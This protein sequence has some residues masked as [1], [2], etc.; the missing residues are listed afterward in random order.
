MPDPDMNPRLRLAIQEARAENMPKDN[1]ER[2]IKKAL[3]GDLANYEAV[4]YEGYA[5]GG[6]AVIVEA[7]TDNRNRTGGVVR[8]VFTKYGG[9]LGATGSVSHMFNHIGEITYKAEAGSA[10]AVLEAAIEPGPTMFNRT[11]T[12][13]S[14]VCAFE[15]LWARSPLHSRRSSAKRKASKRLEAEPDDAGRRGQRADDLENAC[16]ARRRRRRAKRL[17]EL[18]DLGRGFEEA[19]GGVMALR[20][21]MAVLRG[22]HPE[23]L[24][25]TL[26]HWMAG[27]SQAME[28]G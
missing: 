6:V 3:G 15:S 19:D 27:S 23:Q 21:V 24:V 22:G 1:I 16:R 13:T 25:R 5:P 9:N 11:P 20:H 28:L 4:R 18:R 17:C 14:S 26:E 12:V 10:E 8:S 2:A 7:L